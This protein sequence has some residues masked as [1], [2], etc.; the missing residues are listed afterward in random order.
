[1][2]FP[3]INS[4]T[5]TTRTRTRR[6]NA[7][8]RTR[9]RAE[10]RRKREANPE[11]GRRRSIVGKAA[12][13]VLVLL[14]CTVPIILLA[15]PVSYVPLIAFV[16]TLGVSFGYLQVLKRSFSFSESQM[17]RSCERGREVGMHI[18]L[19][20]SSVFPYPRVEI[21]FFITD[22]FGEYDAMRTM[23]VPLAP[24][25]TAGYDFDARF[26]HLG[27]Y[28]AGIDHI[29][30]YDLLGLFT[31]RI[32]NETRRSVVVR[33]R[34]FDFYQ[35]EVDEV[36][37]DESNN[38]LKAIAD[39]STDYSSVREYR[40]GDPLKT[41]HWNLSARSADGTMYTRLFETYVAP[42]LCIVMDSFSASDDSEELMA[43]FDGIV[44]S[45]ASLSHFARAQGIECTISYLDR[46]FEPA[47]ACLASADDADELVLDM[48]RIGNEEKH[49]GQAIIPIELL[50]AEGTGS[51][52]HSNV[53]F[54]TSRVNDEIATAL[55]D[56]A[57]RKRNPIL[58]LTVPNGLAGRERAE[59]LA[60]VRRLD[61]AG[62]A[63]FIIESN[64]QETKV[65]TK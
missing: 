49:P 13:V 19:Q 5:G 34:L 16:L 18:E 46:D 56:T 59:Y 42:T 65:A 54:A 17:F 39:D 53:A 28:E 24:R 4:R 41:I 33:P 35:P 37:D 23:T 36:S 15:S 63:C 47:S 9:R 7:A 22:L 57:A 52:G 12:L 50:R 14:F 60:P 51:A 40:Y 55:I 32:E 43:L 27:R 25:E 44:E 30:L 20:N 2:A 31:A 3:K 10:R 48:R 29:V 38:A 11:H 8:V 45:A 21:A 62:V 26:S 64:E 1:M 6:Q 61:S 58:L